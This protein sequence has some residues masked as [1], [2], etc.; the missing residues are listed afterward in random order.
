MFSL[1]NKTAD[2]EERAATLEYEGSLS[3]PKS[4]KQARAEVREVKKIG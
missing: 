3:R 2:F 4:E 1:D